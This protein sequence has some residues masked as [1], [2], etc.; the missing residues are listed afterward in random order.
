[1]LVLFDIDGTML[2]TS[3]VGIKAMECAGRE[4]FDGSFTVQDIEFAGRLDPMIIDDLLEPWGK[5]GCAEHRERFREGY[6][7]HL[8]LFVKEPGITR[9]LPGVV[10]LID[11]VDRQQHGVLGLVTG[12]YPETGFTKISAAGIDPERFKINAWGSDSHSTPPTRNDLPGVAMSRYA[13]ATGRVLQGSE[14]VI[15][16]DT[17]HDVDCAM[18]HG[19][20]CIATA[21]GMYTRGVLDS[22][23]ADL[24]VDDL[25]DTAMLA[26]WIFAGAI[27]RN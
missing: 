22:T 17:P 18:A 4:I 16:G 27:S 13:E 12:N 15:I 7:R 9:A 19:C 1:M 2:T 8:E 24:V 6:G 14:V 20:R 25:S 21:T 10:E 23:R 26:E 5:R 3:R 11:E